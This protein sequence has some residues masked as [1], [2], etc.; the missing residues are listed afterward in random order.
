[1]DERD[2]N[3]AVRSI[4]RGGDP[5]R[6]LAT[7]FAPSA[8]R[9]KLF[10]IYALNVELARIGLEVQEPTLGE[11][12]LEWWR[13]ALTRA[14]AGEAT[15]HPVADAAGT[16][17]LEGDVDRQRLFGLIE[18]RRFDVAV[19]IMP[20][21]P[22]LEAYLENTAGALF[23]LAAEILGTPGGRTNGAAQPAGLAYGLTGLMRALPLHAS[24]G[25]VDL[26]ADMLRQ[27]GTNPD[28]VLAGE[29]SEGLTALLAE[30]RE[31][32]AATLTDA[33]AHVAT[34]SSQV[35]AAYL[36]LA[37]VDPYLAALRKVAADP[38]ARVAELNPL[39]RLWRL[40][41]WRL[42]EEAQ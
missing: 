19:K 41:T 10:A 6:Y 13:D 40:T 24:K 7:L 35:Q 20:D 14:G 17:L 26:P 28:D 36:P 1:M 16:L 33:K 23:G 30:L 22:S 2:R 38:F 11:I 29:A 39:Y 9:P 25:R 8:A 3:L 18:A 31:K 12:R 34:L 21:W 42:V 37:L 5:D 32:A 4:V 27:H 15:G